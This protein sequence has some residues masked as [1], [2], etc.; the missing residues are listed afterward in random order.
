MSQYPLRAN[1]RSFNNR[2]SF[3][4]TNSFN[5]ANSFNNVCN[6]N[7]G[8]VDETAEILAWFSPLE[9]RIR[10]QNIREHRVKHVGDWFLQSEEYQKWYDGIH[11]SEPNNST[12]F[13]CGDPGVGKT[14]IR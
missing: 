9:P 12:L 3:N 5:N 6:V 4:N 14:Y 8:S 13:C 7:F 11:E 2:N 1:I 10:H